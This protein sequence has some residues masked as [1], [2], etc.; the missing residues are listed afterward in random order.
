MVVAIVAGVSV[1]E[2]E[3]SCLSKYGHRRSLNDSELK[4]RKLGP[5][6][7]SGE[8]V[9]KAGSL[10]SDTVIPDKGG[11]SIHAC[12]TINWGNGDQPRCPHPGRCAK[13]TT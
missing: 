7:T 11:L 3:W 1:N 6:L 8:V 12:N 5:E 9:R 4:R 13:L 10:H 2:G